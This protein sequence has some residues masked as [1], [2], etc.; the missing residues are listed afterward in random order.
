MD[1][2]TGLRASS[3][4]QNFTK[5]EFVVNVTD[6]WAIGWMQ[7]DAQGQ[8]FVSE[9]GFNEPI[10]FGPTRE[11]NSSDPQATI[12]LSSLAE[13]QTV[14]VSPQDIIG[15]IDA[16]ADFQGYKVEY[17][18][19][20]NPG[21]WKFL[22][23]SSQPV[24]Q[25]GKVYTWDLKDIP[26]GLVTLRI[27]MISIRGGFAERKVHLNIMVPTPTPTMTPTATPT[28]TTTATLT[29]TPSPTITPSATPSPTVLPSEVPPTE[30][31]T[32]PPASANP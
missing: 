25:T 31:P 18:F 22:F 16:S 23:D 29:P 32:Q 17:G 2:W 5:E 19:G 3:T 9:M 26:P 24:N 15:K 20:D 21:E 4:C 8:D 10:R 12:E 11:C 6:P 14:T 30:T 13:G 1:T 28:L 7:N 27:T